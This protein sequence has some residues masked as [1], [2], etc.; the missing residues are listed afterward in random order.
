MGRAVKGTITI[1]GHEIAITN[2][3]KP[4]WPEAGVTKALYLRKLAVLAP[5]L[6]KYCHQRLLTVIRWPHGIHGDFFYQKNAPHPRPDYIETAL[7]DGIEYIVLGK[8]PQLLWLGNQAALEFHP[9]LHLAGSQLPCEWMIDLDPSREVEPRIMEAASIV[10]EVLASLGLDSV[11]KTSGAT[12]VQII[13]PIR[14]GI[15]FDELRSIG[16]L[17]GQFVTEK[18]PH[19]FTLERLKKDRGTAIYFDYL[20]HYQGK[21]LAAPY[22]PRA[23][24]G[25]TVSTPLTWEEVRQD[26]SPLDYHLLNI[27]ERLNQIGDLIDKVPPQPVEDLLKHMRSKTH[28]T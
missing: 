4:L 12:G 2:P 11:P 5:F 6:L 18:H 23:R 28:P 20:Q 17:V 25:A 10:G 27:E 16:L 14:P 21:T 22:T 1:E 3:D 8:L 15:T 7:H 26:V 13:V 19:L 9:S 24:P